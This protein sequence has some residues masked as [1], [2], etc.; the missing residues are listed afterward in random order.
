MEIY[1][2][3]L[4]RCCC[5]ITGHDRAD[6]RE[7]LRDLGFQGYLVKGAPHD[8]QKQAFLN[9][10]A[11]QTVFLAG[12]DTCDSAG[13]PRL[14]ER[15]REVVQLVVRGMTSKD[16][17][18]ALHIAVGTVDNIIAAAMHALG[19]NNRAQLIAKALSLGLVSS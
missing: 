11:G 8:T 12:D 16:I 7:R 5:V 18:A 14:T 1:R 13:A 17:S 6:F 19:A 4:H 10:F 3:R 9:I 15:Q 2:R